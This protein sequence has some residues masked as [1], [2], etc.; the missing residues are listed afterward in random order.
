MLIFASTLKWQF[1]WYWICT[2]PYAT[3]RNILQIFLWNNLFITCLCAW[4]HWLLTKNWFLRYLRFQMLQ[5]LPLFPVAKQ[6]VQFHS[7]S[8]VHTLYVHHINQQGKNKTKTFNYQRT[9]KK[10][11]SWTSGFQK[12]RYFSCQDRNTIKPSK[13]LHVNSEFRGCKLQLLK[14]LS[15]VNKG[16]L[17][18]SWQHAFYWQFGRTI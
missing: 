16:H 3:K 5:V 4:K 2:F 13:N 14:A 6:F 18:S 17:I 8:W 12:S 1:L 9:C 11:T 10:T 7:S 15:F